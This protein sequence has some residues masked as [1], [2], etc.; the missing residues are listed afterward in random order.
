MPSFIHRKTK[1]HFTHIRKNLFDKDHFFL[2]SNNICLNADK[3]SMH[4]FFKWVGFNG[5][6]QKIDFSPQISLIVTPNKLLIKYLLNY[7]LKLEI[8]PKIFKQ[9][10]YFMFLAI[11]EQ[12]LNHCI[13]KNYYKRNYDKKFSK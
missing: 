13:K 7:L 12:N 5:Y 10:N 1:R 4:R 3:H 8:L 11:K 9:N 2:F 6:P